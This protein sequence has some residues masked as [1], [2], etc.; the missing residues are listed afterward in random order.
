VI[1]LIAFDA[2]D[3][4][5]H[6]EILY[7]TTQER[8]QRLLAPYGQDGWTKQELYQTEMQNLPYF[9][10]GIKGFTLSM[11]E[12]AIRVTGGRIESNVV[13]EI[14]NLAK[15]MVEAPVQLLDH[16]ADAIA[17]LA[18]THRL[19]IITK[20]DLLDQERKVA[21]S[22]LAPYFSH[23]EIVID[24]TS[25]IYQTL[26][27]QY[28]IA[29]QRF[30]MVGNSLRSDILPVVALGGHAVHIP[31]QVTWAHEAAAVDDG[32]PQGYLKLEHMGLLPAL[33]GQL[34]QQ[35]GQPA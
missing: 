18:K 15:E 14:I 3:T 21:K 1:D 35:G 11:I 16:V 27:A 7:A 10:Y 9:G 28:Q 34:E 12:T 25:R 5:W 26:F 2:D 23:I 13:Q 4:L 30:L 6:N 19:M 20:G 31:Y 17:T 33:V 8:F 29:P 24:K 22:G 32:A